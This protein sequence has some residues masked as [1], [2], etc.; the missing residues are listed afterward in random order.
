MQPTSGVLKVAGR[1]IG[2]IFVAV[3]QLIHAGI[4]LA[5][6]LGVEGIPMVGVPPFAALDRDIIRAAD[7]LAAAIIIIGAVGLL[8]MRS[9]GWV[10]SMLVVGAGL[11]IGL[12]RV[13]HGNPDYLALAFDVV[14]AF[15]LN[16]RSV[17][18]IA[19]R[20]LGPRP[21]ARP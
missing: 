15:Y 5:A 21:I 3:V 14:S 16:Q 13:P 10:I 11:L 6:G 12:L 4:L 2:L 19:A 20:H 17:R 1:P 9:W 18:M 7:I 8:L